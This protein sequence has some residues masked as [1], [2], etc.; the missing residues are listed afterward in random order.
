MAKA[1]RDTA[2]ATD[3]KVFTYYQPIDGLWSHES[4]LALIDVWRRS[5]SKAGWEPIVLSEDDVRQHPRYHFFKEHFW[6][7]PAIYGNDYAGACFMR[8]FAASIH[9]G[10]MLTDFDVINHSFPPRKPTP[11]RMTIF[12]DGEHIFAGAFLASAQHYLDM[13][14]IFA[15]WVPDEHDTKHT[16]RV[17]DIPPLLEGQANCDDLG[18]L[19]RMFETKTYTKPPWLEHLPGCSLWDSPDCATAPLVHYGYKMRETGHWPKHEWIEKL[20]PI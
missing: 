1:S 5:W 15:A 8:Y 10:G 9:G 12:A 17:F 2:V 16:T 20:R 19:V 3:M 11:E 7:K 18:L 6:S 14:E 13:A 4:Q